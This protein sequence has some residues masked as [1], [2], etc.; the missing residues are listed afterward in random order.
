MRPFAQAGRRRGVALML[1]LWLVV[2]LGAIAA[3]TA[4]L[5]RGEVD[6]VSNLRARSAARYAAESGVVVARARLEALLATHADPSGRAR[7]FTILERRFADLREASIGPARFSV[8][9]ADLNARLDLNHAEPATLQNFLAQF[10]PDREAA[11]VAAAIED[12]RDEDG[13]PRPDGAEAAEYERAGSP[14]VP[15]NAPFDRLETV[16]R[17][18]GMTDSLAGLIAPYVTVDGDGRVNLNTAPH[19]VLAALPGIGPAGARELL[20]R[21]GRGELFSSAAIV[22]ELTAR[23]ASSGA[24]G[25]TAGVIDMARTSTVPSRILV[26]SRGWQQDHPL[27]H[28]IQAVYAVAGTRL[29]LRAWRERDL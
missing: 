4:T 25:A 5:V 18:R 17:V 9:V 20:A 12:W 3:A 13:L 16:R 14:F 7:A 15:T 2:V 1:A 6:V 28:E 22:G 19:A 21:R 23:G 24:P 27:T 11:R 10:A 8:A 29:T 26:V